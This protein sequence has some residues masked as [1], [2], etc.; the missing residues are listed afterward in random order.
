MHLYLL[1]INSKYL[2]G[3]A[4]C[5]V[6]KLGYLFCFL[7]IVFP[8]CAQNKQVLYGLETVPQSLLLNPGGEVPQQSH[9]AIPFLSQIHINAGASGVTVYDIFQEGGDINQRINEAIFSMT[10]KDFFTVTQQWDIVNFGW[11]NREDVYFSGGMYQ[12]LDVIAYFPK[13]F[14]ILASQGNRDFLDVPF[15][16]SDINASAELLAVWHLGINKQ[17]TKKLRL[18]GRAKLYSSLINVRSTNN[19]GTFTTRQSESGVNV[20]EHVVDRLDLTVHTS[21]LL[22]L[23]EKNQGQVLGALIGRSLFSGNYGLGVD[24]GATYD[25]ND[26]LVLSASILD[27]GAMF[28][29]SNT[30]S[31]TARGSYTLD[32]IA[33]LFPPLEENEEA[34]PYYD[35]LEAE[36]AQAIPVDTISRG[37]TYLRPLKFNAQLGYSFGKFVGNKVCDCLDKGS[38]KRI[39]EMGVHVFSIFRPRG[40]QMAGTF[41]YRRRWGNVLSTKFTY[42]ADPFSFTNV[43][44]GLV[45][46][47]GTFNF[48]LAADNLLQIQNL[49][50]ANSVSLQVGFNIKIPQR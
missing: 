25:I 22:S 50:K 4:A 19:S 35:E 24:F 47:I 8:L 1:K 39:N 37:Y 45:A 2:L 11:R 15:Q 21:G 12:E 14:A 49:A 10:E 32:G 38:I 28:Q 7:W 41:Y 13:D 34:F 3:S 20:F 29:V 43:G 42:T 16:F 44:A 27:L 48:Y 31:Y 5:H 46:D 18:G 23:D 33:L 36:I 17:V 6:L 26:Q 30:E 9:F 40:P